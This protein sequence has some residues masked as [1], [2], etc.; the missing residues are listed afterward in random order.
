M[1][2]EWTSK[3]WTRVITLMRKALKKEPNREDTK[4][5]YKAEIFAEQAERDEEETELLADDD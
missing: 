3:E 4:L 5:L 1:E 2:I